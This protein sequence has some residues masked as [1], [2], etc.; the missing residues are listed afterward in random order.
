MFKPKILIV[1]D[2]RP[3]ANAL[4]RAL[5]EQYEVLI[6]TSG[7]EALEILSIHQ[8]A[9][10]IT[11]QRMPNITG[12]QLVEKSKELSPDS[13]SILIS[14]YTDIGAMIDAINIGRFRGYMPKPLDLD[15]L[16]KIIQTSVKEYQ[17][18]FNDKEVLRQ[19]GNALLRAREEINALRKM[20]NGLVERQ[21]TDFF[22]H[23]NL[24][25]TPS[26]FYNNVKSAEQQ[27][28]LDAL[29][30]GVLMLNENGTIQ[31]CNPALVSLLNL[32]NLHLINTNDINFLHLR[33]VTENQVL[34]DAVTA[35]LRGE[36][37]LATIQQITKDRTMRI[38]E[39][40]CSPIHQEDGNYKA[41]LLLQDRTTERQAISFLNGMQSVLRLGDNGKDLET[42]LTQ[43][44]AICTEAIHA[45]GAALYLMPA[46]YQN[47][48]L[49]SYNM[50]TDNLIK[51][52]GNL[53]KKRANELERMMQNLKPV[54]AFE[55][56]RENKEIPCFENIAEIQSAILS[57]FHFPLGNSGIFCIT[58]N[59]RRDFQEQE[60]DFLRTMV[61][62]IEEAVAK[63]HT[64]ED[65]ETK[66]HNDP[67]T[68]LNN[69]RYFVHE[70]KSR[71]DKL[72]KPAT[73]L[74]IDVD[75]FKQFND[76]YGHQAGDEILRAIGEVL[77]R[78]TR[79]SDIVARYGGDE[80]IIL[81]PDCPAEK[82]A[83]VINRIQ[84]HLKKIPIPQNG[85]STPPLDVQLSIGRITV[86]AENQMPLD[87]MI[88]QA[89]LDMYQQK[90]Y[91]QG[92]P[93]E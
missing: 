23:G 58:S 2:D 37:V 31:Y 5:R 57:K 28:F 41:V 42:T 49:I 13:I 47:T 64:L 29:T 48:K 93:H 1:D 60:I 61:V 3:V 77:M 19:A 84:Q 83:E 36:F 74:M 78:S 21:L 73:L 39:L 12:T 14:G 92:Q 22:A 70:A 75:E 20:M 50:P 51:L 26:F 68:G 76:R 17:A 40:S 90:P 89:D 66:A 53:K 38:F 54:Q 87:E 80:F 52:E 62:Q 65:L 7:E 82:A 24:E 55:N 63:N 71:L 10:I 44:L 43:F 46:E 8:I 79:T 9:V 27:E 85:E 15:N 59:T 69:Y 86:D 33:E 72:A 4:S 45:N 25:T 16:R 67:I 34:H 6:A 56:V 88:H 18:I 11:D 35:V 91:T 32:P 81:M 30:N